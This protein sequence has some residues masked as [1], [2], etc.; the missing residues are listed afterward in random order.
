[1]QVNW[2]VKRNEN[3]I[4]LGQSGVGKTH[5]A[6]ALAYQAV[7]KR[8]KTQFVTAADLIIPNDAIEVTK[9]S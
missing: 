3:I 5:L 1:M 7:Q 9:L 8:I 2:I 6:I 4:L